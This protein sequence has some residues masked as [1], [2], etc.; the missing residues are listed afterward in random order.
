MNNIIGQCSKCGGDVEI[1]MYSTSST[2]YCTRCGARMAR[3][4]IEMQGGEINSNRESQ[5][6]YFGIKTKKEVQSE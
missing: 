3:P 2:P 4:V 1:P 5:Q 6:E